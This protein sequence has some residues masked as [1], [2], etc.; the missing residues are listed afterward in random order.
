LAERH[1][2][3]E[4]A[5]ALLGQPIFLVGAA[6]RRRDQLEDACSTK[7]RSRRVRMFLETPRLL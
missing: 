2:H 5:A 3:L 4:Q 1:E 7:V 6:V